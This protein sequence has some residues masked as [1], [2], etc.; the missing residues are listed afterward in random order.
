MELDTQRKRL[1]RLQANQL[2]VLHL[3]ST[4]SSSQLCRHQLRTKDV[5]LKPLLSLQMFKIPKRCHRLLE[6]KLEQS[7]PRKK[8]LYLSRK[9]AW[10]SHVYLSTTQRTQS[11]SNRSQRSHSSQNLLKKNREPKVQYSNTLRNNSFCT[12]RKTPTQRRPMKS[13]LHRRT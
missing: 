9:P 13:L 11:N 7:L 2:K 12:N 5:K 8:P 1:Q 3:T 4:T 6:K 10:S